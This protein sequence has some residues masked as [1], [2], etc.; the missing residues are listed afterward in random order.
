MEDSPTYSI[1]T[2]YLTVL[3]VVLL[4]T[5]FICSSKMIRLIKR[6]QKNLQGFDKDIENLNEQQPLEVLYE[7]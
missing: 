4:A 6:I 2:I 5:S 7:E 1:F 3:L